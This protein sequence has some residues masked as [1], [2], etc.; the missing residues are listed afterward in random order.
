MEN[1][2]FLAEFWTFIKIKKKWWLIPSI[3]MLILASI[4]ITIGATSGGGLSPFIY[5]LF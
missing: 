1:Q 3:V 2:G 4:L 5:A